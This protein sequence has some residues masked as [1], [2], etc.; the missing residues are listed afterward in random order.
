MSAENRRRI[1]ALLIWAR[2]SSSR[3]TRSAVGGLLG[4]IE[5]AALVAIGWL[6][7]YAAHFRCSGRRGDHDRHH[8]GQ[9]PEIPGTNG[10]RALLCTSIDATGAPERSSKSTSS[11]TSIG[12][13][14]SPR[15]DGTAAPSTTTRDLDSSTFA[16]A[17]PSNS[18]RA[19]AASGGLQAAW[20]AL[21]QAPRQRKI[22]IDGTPAAAVGLATGQRIRRP[23]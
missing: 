11:R 21:C 5:A 8:R 12:S 20:I 10:S 7:L 16:D 1:I 23:R 13:C 9:Y 2:I 17:A 4:T 15:R 22:F 14:A 3:A 19:G 18:R 6:A